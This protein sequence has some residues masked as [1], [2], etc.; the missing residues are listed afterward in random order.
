MQVLSVLEIASTYLGLRTTFDYYFNEN[1]STLPS[2][3]VQN[4]YALLLLGLNLVVHEICSEY[5]MVKER[6][7][8]TFDENKTFDISDLTYEPSGI[9][10]VTKEGI[11]HNFEIINGKIKSDFEGEGQIEYGIIPDDFD[12][13]DD[14]TL[15]AGR[16]SEKVLA[17]GACMEYKFLKNILDDAKV[18]EKRFYESLRADV[19]S[20][21][22]IVMPKKRG[23]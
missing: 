14:I 19:R 4:D 6:E 9:L 3:A 11:S 23:C 18:F 15:F 13:S 17:L 22:Q 16:V 1:N 10:K 2:S 20:K 12:D 5:I 7:S 21:K 8:V